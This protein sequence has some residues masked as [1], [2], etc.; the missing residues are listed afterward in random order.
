VPYKLKLN[1]APAGFAGKSADHGDKV[2]LILREFLSSEDGKEFTNRLEGWPNELLQIAG[3]GNT[4]ASQVDHMLVHFSREGECFVFVNELKITIKTRVQ[5]DVAK[6][7]AVMSDDIVDITEFRFDDVEIPPEHGVLVV[8]SCGWRKGVYFDFGPIDP[9]QGNR[10]YSLW[11]ILGNQYNYV[12]FQELHSLTDEE[13][14][15]LFS[16][17]WFPFIGLKLKTLKTLI[18]WIRSGYQA[19]KILSLAVKDV[20]SSLSRLQ[21]RWNRYA[22]LKEHRAILDI[23]AERFNS[24]DWVS[25]NSILYPRIEGILRAI[26]KSSNNKVTSQ[27]KM[28]GIPLI[29]S[30]LTPEN[31]SRLFPRQFN[32][33]LSEVYFKSFDPDKPAGISRNSIGHGVAPDTEFS[34][35]SATIGFLIIEQIMWHI[36]PP[37]EQLGPQD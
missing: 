16:E 8:F 19:E 15:I 33:Y 30:G 9:S 35:Q 12:M 6:G 28:A 27:S 10:T 37:A 34:E 36:Q 22:D 23:A 31:N 7:S 13:W 4:R 18:G 32:R 3:K 14:S 26:A 5:R 2:T 1:Q 17:K 11:K 21:S 24:E 25:C 29:V 20:K